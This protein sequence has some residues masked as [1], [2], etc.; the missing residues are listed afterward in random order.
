MNV[1]KRIVCIIENLGS[2]GAERQLSGLAVL[3][4]KQGYEVEVWYYVQKDFYVPFLSENGVK[5]RYLSEAKNPKTRF[6]VLKKYLKEFHA[7][8]V[9]SYSASPSLC[10]CMLKVLG[11]K[12]NAVVSERSTTQH[13]GTRVRVKFF[14]YRWANHVVPNSQTEAN[15][16]STH[17]PKLA[18][19]T[20]TIT[21]FVDTDVFCPDFKSPRFQVEVTRIICVG[22]RMLPKNIPAFMNAIAKVKSDGYNIQV[23]WFGADLHD[24][25]SNQ[26]NETI[27]QLGLEQTFI[28]HEPSQN[29][30]EEYVKA[31]VFCMPSLYEGYPNVLCE[32]MSCG[33]PIL[34]SR[35]SDV[36]YIV[37]E[38]AN[39]FLFDCHSANE[40]AETIVHFINL[41]DDVKLEMARQS[42]EI[43]V[44]LFSMKNFV[45]RYCRIIE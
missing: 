14:L 39:G 4:K 22:R 35:V 3:L 23:D 25:Y 6:F 40:M 1:I 2:G 45:E 7:D 19:K 24:D 28:F 43:A 42:R 21:N 18:S 30:Q 16:I 12:F 13:I 36:P 10:I 34:A 38:G 11:A 33:L 15:F 9:I 32:A 5:S 20:E 27:K 17:F 31:D 8:A 29:I 37:Q 44:Q 41:P 26:C